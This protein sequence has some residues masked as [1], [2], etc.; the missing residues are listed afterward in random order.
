MTNTIVLNS[1]TLTSQAHRPCMGMVNFGRTHCTFE[2]L[3]SGL[4][5]IQ[6]AIL[7]VGIL[8]VLGGNH[9]SFEHNLF[10]RLSFNSRGIMSIAPNS[11]LCTTPATLPESG[12][13]PHMGRPDIQ[14][15]QIEFEWHC[16]PQLFQDDN[17]E[18][19]DWKQ[20]QQ[21]SNNHESNQPASWPKDCHIEL[22]L[23]H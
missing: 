4:P 21:W 1:K 11:C 9:I 13:Q 12:H 19:R 17:K 7:Q 8:L 10:V 6:P 2:V 23:A 20:Q 14:Q 18:A 16:F 5:R 15:A 22:Q 3:G